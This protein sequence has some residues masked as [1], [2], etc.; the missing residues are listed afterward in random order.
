MNLLS[1]G[2]SGAAPGFA[3]L[4]TALKLAQLKAVQ[5]PGTWVLSKMAIVMRHMM[6]LYRLRRSLL[7][8]H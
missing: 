7:L 1:Y 5:Q 2:A 3:V 6:I 4:S 8:D